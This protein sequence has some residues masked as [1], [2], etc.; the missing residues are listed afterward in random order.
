MVGGGRGRRSGRGREG[1]EGGT[2]NGRT[3]GQGLF[4]FHSPVLASAGHV[5][6]QADFPSAKGCWCVP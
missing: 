3:W 6:Y 1:G 2:K 5:A 4:S